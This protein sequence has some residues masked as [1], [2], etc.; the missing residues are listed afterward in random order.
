MENIS[1]PTLGAYYEQGFLRHRQER[2]RASALLE[3][4]DV[5]PGDPAAMF[6]TLSGGNQQKALLAKW[7]ETRP[8][9]FIM[10]EPTQGVDIG[11]RQRIFSQITDAAD[12]GTSFILASAEYDDLANLC[13]RV[14]V[15]RNGQIVSDVGGAALT[16]DRLVDLCLRD[17]P[18][19]GNENAS[20]DHDGRAHDSRTEKEEG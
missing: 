14:L 2:R 19:R 3:T 16:G 11:A 1:L 15:F 13:D 9:V 4:F 12:A 20:G 8:Q 18:A 10:H 6:K 17:I 7:F 5:R